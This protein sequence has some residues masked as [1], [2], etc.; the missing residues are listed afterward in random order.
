[1][2]PGVLDRPDIEWLDADRGSSG[3]DAFS[4][5]R[6]DS[7]GLKLVFVDSTDGVVVTDTVTTGDDFSRHC[8]VVLDDLL[9]DLSK[10]LSRDLLDGVSA[11]IWLHVCASSASGLFFASN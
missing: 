1:M 4:R 11:P 7:Y 3:E 6:Q 8:S 2:L 10:E 5:L 9:L